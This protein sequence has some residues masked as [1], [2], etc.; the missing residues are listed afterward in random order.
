MDIL[1]YCKYCLNEWWGKYF[2][3]Q[4]LKTLPIQTLEQLT[5]S[6]LRATVA[7]VKEKGFRDVPVKHQ[8]V[9]KINIATNNC[10][11]LLNSIER[12]YINISTQLPVKND[13][14]IP[15]VRLL[16]DWFVNERNLPV[17]AKTVI[18]RLVEELDRYDTELDRYK[19]DTIW[20]HYVRRSSVFFLDATQIFNWYLE[21]NDN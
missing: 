19:H 4:S 20:A 2:K 10:V 11:E 7:K 16:D 12:S 9:T 6:D 13:S 17:D 5:Y 14:P 1:T 15:T 8:L 18:K 21:L 3:K